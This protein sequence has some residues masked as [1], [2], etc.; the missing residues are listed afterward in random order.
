MRSS[1]APPEEGRHSPPSSGQTENNS[2][3]HNGGVG[4]HKGVRQC[5]EQRDAVATFSR[6]VLVGFSLEL[7]STCRADR[8]TSA[9]DLT[10]W[11]LLWKPVTRSPQ[12]QPLVKCLRPPAGWDT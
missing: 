4:R 12:H 3:S 1:P 6:V 8:Q 9:S 7:H 11:L 2:F 5:S 10:S